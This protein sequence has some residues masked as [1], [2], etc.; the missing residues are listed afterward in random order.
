MNVAFLFNS[1]HPS[2]GGYYGIPLLEKVLSTGSLQKSSRFMRVSVG[3]IMTHMA[4]AGKTFEYLESL[5]HEVYKPRDYDRIHWN[6]LHATYRTATVYCFLFQNMTEKC[7]DELNQRLIDIEPAYLGAMDV[8]FSDHIQLKFFRNS[9]CEEYRINGLE[10]AL[11]VE[12]NDF[13]NMDQLIKNIFEKYSF[14]THYEDIGA[15]RTFWDGFDTL[16][17][18]TRI[19]DF[20]NAFIAMSGVTEDL[21]NDVIHSLEELHPKLFDK[22]ASAARALQRA[23]TEEDLA[24]ASLSGRRILESFA[25]YLY[26]PR[27]TLFNNRKIGIKEYRNRLWAY[28]ET[29]L[30]SSDLRDKESKLIILGKEA[31]KL[32]ELFNAGLHSDPSKEAVELAFSRQ[33]QWIQAVIELSPMNARKPYLAYEK[34]LNGRYNIL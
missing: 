15:R 16:K 32:V 6:A 13:E 7:A 12:M 14:T 27:K 1:D 26:P 31:D 10:C 34:E 24:Q 5:C 11:F 29:T 2:L 20:K 30:E 9:L 19:A 22:F 23:E 18:F 21:A 33:L 28:I 25:D 8:D 4:S 3:D 17:H